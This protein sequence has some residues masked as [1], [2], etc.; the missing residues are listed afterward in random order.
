MKR[1]DQMDRWFA[2]EPCVVEPSLTRIRKYLI[3]KLG[4][5]C[6]ECGFIGRNVFTKT[7]VIDLDH[8]DGNRKNNSP[9]NL[10]LLCPNCHA[11]TS[12]YKGANTR[13]VKSKY[14]IFRPVGEVWA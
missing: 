9:S 14:G 11:Q 2:G 1:T 10:R 12:T 8:I 4:P 3:Q 5:A 7:D 6:S 13:K